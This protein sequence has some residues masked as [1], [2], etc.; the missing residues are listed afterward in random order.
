MKFDILLASVFHC[1]RKLNLS[2]VMK[3]EVKSV[4]MCSILLYIIQ[5]SIFVTYNTTIQVGEITNVIY[6][7]II[8]NMLG[9]Y[10]IIIA[11][12]RFT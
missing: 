11:L 5:N 7:D 1:V 6:I 12:F 9:P 10:S 2:L 4:F 3:L 8:H